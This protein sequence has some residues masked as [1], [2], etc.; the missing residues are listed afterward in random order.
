[1]SQ[2]LA[3]TIQE[4]RGTTMYGLVQ[5]VN[6]TGAV[7]TVDVL[8]ADGM[9]HA[10][11]QVMQPYGVATCA[12]AQG[13]VVQ[14]A[15]LGADPGNLS[16]LPP[17]VPAARYGN[18]LPGEVVIYDQG[19][20]RVALRQGGTIDV[21]A[22]TLISIVA[23]QVGITATGGVNIH[24]NLS[25]IGTISATEDVVAN[26]EGTPVS[27]INHVHSGVQSGGSDTGPPT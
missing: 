11:I 20:D 6:D 13:S 19:G 9:L 4:L 7:Q 27:L 5:A 25:V 26:D 14:L 23:P 1:M 16:A 10:G 12:P 18:L 21:F 22:A 3:E 24:G 17:M 15:A 2:R 8:T